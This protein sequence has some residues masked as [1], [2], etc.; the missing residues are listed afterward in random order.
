MDPKDQ[1]DRLVQLVDQDLKAR[2]VAGVPREL[3]GQRE[4]QE[5]RAKSGK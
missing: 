1:L 2:L 4:I 3:Q 5:I